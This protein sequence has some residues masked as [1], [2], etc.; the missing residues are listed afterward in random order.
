MPGKFARCM[1]LA[2]R[3]P[4]P[5]QRYTRHIASSCRVSEQKLPDG[6]LRLMI[7]L[8]HQARNFITPHNLDSAIN[9]AFTPE[10]THFDSGPVRLSLSDITARM[11][12]SYQQNAVMD[13]GLFRGSPFEQG[14][15]SRREEYV[16]GALYGTET[17]GEHPGLPGL[18]VVRD[19]VASGTAERNG[20]PSDQGNSYQ[21]RSASLA[22]CVYQ[23]SRSIGH[24]VLW[25]LE[26]GFQCPPSLGMLRL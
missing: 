15:S 6:K 11:R 13:D 20:D 8:H 9:R 12:Q 18:E 23:L 5:R 3:T 26:C 22:E 4:R 2:R 19:E 24:F 14:G 1:L 16:Q 25:F 7:S 10:E 17:V 21:C